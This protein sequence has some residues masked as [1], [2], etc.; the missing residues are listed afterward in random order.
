MIEQMSQNISGSPG[1]TLIFETGMS[2]T[3]LFKKKWAEQNLTRI[4][5]RFDIRL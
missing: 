3:K 1:L 2:T 5:I 4:E